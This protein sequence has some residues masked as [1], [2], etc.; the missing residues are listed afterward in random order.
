MSGDDSLILSQF[1]PGSNVVQSLGGDAGVGDDILNGEGVVSEVVYQDILFDSENENGTPLTHLEEESTVATDIT[2]D[3]L[4]DES[5]AGG[6][7]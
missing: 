6:V 5:V 7:G 2:E 1:F 3:D 4:D